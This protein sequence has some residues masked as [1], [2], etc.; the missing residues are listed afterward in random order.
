[1]IAVWSS[2]FDSWLLWSPFQNRAGLETPAD[3]VENAFAVTKLVACGPYTSAI[4]YVAVAKY[5]AIHN[6]GIG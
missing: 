4:E 3:V 1:M 2:T 5:G 6:R